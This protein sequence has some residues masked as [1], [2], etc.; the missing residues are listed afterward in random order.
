[1]PKS[2]ATILVIDDDER[3]R[4]SLRAM[5]SAKQYDVRLAADGE[6]GLSM[7]VDVLPDAVILDMAMPGMNGLAVCRALREWYTGPIIILSAQDREADKITALDLGADDYVLKPCPIGELLARVR[8][9]LRRVSTADTPLPVIRT[10]DLTVDLG[11]RRVLL[12]EQEVALTPT[13][14][15]LLAL[16]ARKADCVVTYRTLVEEVWQQEYFGDTRAVSV[17]VS[18]LRKKIEPLPD[19]PRYLITEHG[20]G[21]RFVTG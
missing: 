3:M 21:F 12:G 9:H 11:K 7:A 19:S 14:Y 4:R 18:N 17:H 8:A 20:V 2:L 5:L 16:L 10:G 1:M 6:E 13:E 15:D